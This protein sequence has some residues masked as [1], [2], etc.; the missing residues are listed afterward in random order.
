ME[1]GR[2]WACFATSVLQLSNKSLL[3]HLLSETRVTREHDAAMNKLFDWLARFEA[4]LNETLGKV[5][6][7]YAKDRLSEAKM[8]LA[9]LDELRDKIQ[10]FLDEVSTVCYIH[11]VFKVLVLCLTRTSFVDV[12]LG[13]CV[14]SRN[15]NTK[16]QLQP[17]LNKLD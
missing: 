2:G 14:G 7:F 12:F 15:V 17:F 13:E 3:C 4:Q 8:Y 10:G 6:E 9:Q 1:G 5:K 16:Q 11:F